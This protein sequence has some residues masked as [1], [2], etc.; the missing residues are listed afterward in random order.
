[1]FSKL[2]DRLGTAGLVIAVIAL[3][4]ALAGTAFAASGLNGK[5]K[6]EVKK[7]AKQY[8]GKR[9]PVGPAGPAGA[10]GAKGD[11]GAKG[12]KGDAGNAGTPGAPG[13]D[14]NSVVV[15]SETAG[16]NCTSGGVSVAVEG[17][18]KKYVC[19]GQNGGEELPEFL[20][21]GNTET[22]TWGGA[23]TQ[24]KYKENETTGELEAV[25]G[26]GPSFLPISIPVPLA[27][28]PEPIFIGTGETEKPGCPG[29][30]AEGLPEAEEGKLCVYARTFTGLP[31]NQGFFD[32]TKSFTPGSSP[33]G[34]V[35][36][37][38][39][40]GPECIAYGVWAVTAE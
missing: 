5:Q 12:D 36:G 24:T 7:I 35:L 37:F 40:T 10:P 30:N 32:P 33:T 15:N 11:T 34:T 39:C 3:V 18:T 28:A 23:V 38:E 2:H 17:G 9:G 13:A 6:K 19:N 25:P 22:G 31:A 8:A 29:V 26:G 16:A 1:M 4:A 14:G 20:P 21:S 27:E